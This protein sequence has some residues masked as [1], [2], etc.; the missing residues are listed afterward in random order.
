MSKTGKDTY[1]T[2]WNGSPQKRLKQI[3]DY[4]KY[5]KLEPLSAEKLTNELIQF[6]DKL[7]IPP[8]SYR[9]I[10][11]LSNER[12]QYRTATYKKVYR[13]IFRVNEKRRHVIIT[14]PFSQQQGSS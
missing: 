1:Q 10:K 3:H 5:Q 4:I 9:V 8:G 6:G 14:K 2:I 7:G 12:F 13:F 11:E